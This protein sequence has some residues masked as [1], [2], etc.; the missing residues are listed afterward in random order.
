MMPVII[1]LLAGLAMCFTL[2]VGLDARLQERKARGH[3]SQ[4]VMEAVMGESRHL[5]ANH[6]Y[7]KADVYYHAGYYPSIFDENLAAGEVHLKTESD[8]D[9]SG[10]DDHDTSHVKFQPT[11]WISRFGRNF[12]P[13]Q[14]IHANKSSEARE[15][16]PWLRLSADLDPHRVETYTVA[17]YWLRSRI[18]N[19]DAAE[20]FLREGLRNNPN[21]SE[22]L[23]ELGRVFWENRKDA[24]RARNVWELALTKVLDQQVQSAPSDNVLYG[25]I[26]IHLARLEESQQNWAK[27]LDYFIALK[28]VSPSPKAVQ[29]WIDYVKARQSGNSTYQQPQTP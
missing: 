21:S 4:S 15:V 6:F 19:V 25:Q 7:I 13:S 3:S 9:H 17:A 14:H 22:I 29:A 27:A 24:T 5:L 20:A 10:K 2:A 16:L 28:S 8:P 11:D 23:F 1:P 12:K 18:G 26:L